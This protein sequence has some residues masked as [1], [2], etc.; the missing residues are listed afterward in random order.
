[1]FESLETIFIFTF[2]TMK[3]FFQVNS[4]IFGEFSISFL[5]FKFTC[6]LPIQ[7][8]LFIFKF[9]FKVVV[10]YLYMNKLKP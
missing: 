3:Q 8:L 5:V 10:C 6:Y 2:Y 7:D 9:I 4:F 1:M